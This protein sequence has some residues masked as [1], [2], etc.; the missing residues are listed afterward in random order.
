MNR[1]AG[2]KSERASNDLKHLVHEKQL[3]KGHKKL[4]VVPLIKDAGALVFH[5]HP[6]L[7][8]ERKRQKKHTFSEEQKTCHEL[9]ALLQKDSQS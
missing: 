8:H 1:G 7:L 6:V 4:F 3:N 9:N 2:K 5:Y